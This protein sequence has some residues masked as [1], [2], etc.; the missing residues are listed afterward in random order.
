MSIP[1]HFEADKASERTAEMDFNGFNYQF[2]RL[3]RTVGAGFFFHFCLILL[4][5]SPG[6]TIFR[7]PMEK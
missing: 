6:K 4:W 3:K 1:V 7:L 5:M 2:S